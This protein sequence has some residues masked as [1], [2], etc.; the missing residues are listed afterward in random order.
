MKRRREVNKYQNQKENYLTLLSHRVEIV[1][2]TRSATKTDLIMLLSI[3]TIN[4]YFI[5]EKQ[6]I[7][8][9]SYYIF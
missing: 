6:K 2:V 9:S 5:S 7:F 1:L 3:H 8:K 4:I